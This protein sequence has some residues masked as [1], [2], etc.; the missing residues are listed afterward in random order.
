V[1]QR[2][3]RQHDLL[4]E[5]RRHEGARSEHLEEEPHRLLPGVPG[6]CLEE[7]ATQERSLPRLGELPQGQPP[8]HPEEDARREEPHGEQPEPGDAA[9]R[10]VEPGAAREEQHVRDLPAVEGEHREQVEEVHGRDE[11]GRL[12]PPRTRPHD[13]EGAREEEPGDR[14]RQEDD[15]PL[16][17]RRVVLAPRRDAAEE[18]HEEDRRV[19][20]PQRAHREVM[21]ELVEED[22]GEE[23][24]GRRR[25]AGRVPGSEDE[26]R[27]RHQEQREEEARS[28]APARHLE[29]AVVRRDVL[30]DR[31]DGERS[32]RGLHHPHARDPLRR[33]T[34][35]RPED[36]AR[37]R[38]GG[39]PRHHVAAIALTAERAARDERLEVRGLALG[40]AREERVGIEGGRR[41]AVRAHGRGVR[42][43]LQRDGRRER[44]VHEGA[45]RLA[46]ARALAAVE[47]PEHATVGA[48]CRERHRARHG[49]IRDRR[50]RDG[51]VR[52][53][54]RVHEA[55]DEARRV[56]LR[57]LALHRRPPVPLESERDQLVDRL[58]QT[59]A[60]VRG[61]LFLRGE[62]RTRLPDS[63]AE[64]L[65][66]DEQRPDEPK[67]DE[68][69]DENDQRLHAP[70][71]HPPFRAWRC[72]IN[73]R[74]YR[75]SLAP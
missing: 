7:L 5:R 27:H 69:D 13:R 20:V 51:G 42:L 46:E 3:A 35:H 32:Q 68:H 73:P 30:L 28:R 33:D 14:A 4:A 44:L 62:A 24:G 21:P 43:K 52:P 11:E 1:R 61:D 15:H 59:V 17:D 2:R 74:A 66:Q 36:G 60:D 39:S 56:S 48:V 65:I 10:G 6:A 40:V 18:R 26:E 57:A 25:G 50:E 16:R 34:P 9:R 38:Q 63:Q 45:R 31:N 22:D 58:A 47:R 23:H 49:R 67:D 19:D 75:A 53:R 72:A 64:Q 41:E 37:R 71:P 12:S 29:L 8:E 70:S 54:R 55:R